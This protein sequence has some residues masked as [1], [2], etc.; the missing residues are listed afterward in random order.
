M[1]IL[2]WGTPEYSVPT[3]LALHAA[4]HEIVGVVTQPDRRRGRGKQLMPS[5]IKVCAQSLGLTVFT[6]DR[7]KTDVGCQKELS[8]LKADASV[9]VAFG[10]I[11]PK[12]VLEQPPLGCWNGHGSLL[13]RWRGAG[14]IQWALLE[15]DSETG[16]GIMAMEEG[17]DTG[18]VLL[19]QRLPI[20]LNQNSHDLGEKLS[21]LTATLMV[22]ALDLILKA[23]V[24]TEPDRLDRLN[25]RY[26][27]QE[28]SYA[29]MLKKEDFQIK[30]SDPALRTHR[31][32]MGLSLIHI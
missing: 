8:N 4:G 17:L 13:P 14:P 3:L 7:I 18:P 24:G 19:E 25:V 28:M 16:V 26:Q 31:K 11:L 22:E 10:Q 20:S 15:G 30:W 29:R 12:S 1:K 9:V 2:Y 6:P 27:G 32:V 23:G 5:A 21:Q